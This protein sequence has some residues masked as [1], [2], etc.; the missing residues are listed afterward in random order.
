MTTIHQS[1]THLHLIDLFFYNR[2]NEQVSVLSI[3]KKL[4]LKSSIL[5]DWEIR[6]QADISHLFILI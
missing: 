4:F 2:F 5:V 3:N 6:F 1:V